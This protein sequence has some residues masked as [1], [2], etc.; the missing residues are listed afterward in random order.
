MGYVALV[1]NKVITV[2]TTNYSE[3]YRYM[4]TSRKHH[5]ITDYGVFMPASWESISLIEW[6]KGGVERLVM[7]GNEILAG[8]LFRPS[9]GDNG[10]DNVRNM[11]MYTIHAVTGKQDG[12]KLPD[13]KVSCVGKTIGFADDSREF[14]CSDK[15]D[16]EILSTLFQLPSDDPKLFEQM[17]LVGG[18]LANN[19]LNVKFK[20]EYTLQDIRN[21]LKCKKLINISDMGKGLTK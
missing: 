21:Y 16:S 14:V 12:N 15:G 13:I 5:Y 2:N 10:G 7:P 20:T 19:T 1:D 3:Y 6:M 9:P 18:G 8:I 11:M 17:L 4:T